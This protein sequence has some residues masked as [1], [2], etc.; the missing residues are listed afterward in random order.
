M[1]KTIIKKYWNVKMPKSARV[2]NIIFLGQNIFN[3]FSH[4]MPTT[5][6]AFCLIYK[7]TSDEY[8]AFL[9]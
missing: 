3:F 7:K 4:S 1:D 8:L 6:K 5:Y 9:E 2:F